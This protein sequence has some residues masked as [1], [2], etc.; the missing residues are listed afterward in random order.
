MDYKTLFSDMTKYQQQL[1][2]FL[3]IYYNEINKENK[4][5]L[6]SI[7]NS[8][9]S[10]KNELILYLENIKT[11]YKEDFFIKRI[12]SLIGKLNENNKNDNEHKFILILDLTEFLYEI[13]NYGNIP[14]K[15]SIRIKYNMTKYLYKE[16]IQIVILI[17]SRYKDKN[18]LPN[19]II[20]RFYEDQF[21]L[22]KY[23]KPTF[24]SINLNFYVSKELK[25]KILK[26]INNNLNSDK[27]FELNPLK[28]EFI[29]YDEDNNFKK[30]NNSDFYIQ[31]KT[32]EVIKS[33]F[34]FVP[35]KLPNYNFQK[36][37]NNEDKNDEDEPKDNEDE[38]YKN[39]SSFENDFEES[40]SSFSNKSSI[41]NEEDDIH[42]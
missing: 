36:Q 37:K 24:I 13:Y 34:E 38:K 6:L 31:N 41:S 28:E 30:N 16:L 35:F 27:S 19:E 10:W 23:M 15:S 2:V 14:K 9:E 1:L 8:K 25:I 22:I 39:D 5:K 33:M 40:I 20:L 11:N 12:K 4:D 21:Y 42:D 29:K 32:K 26:A 18:N 7:K 17:Y 3:E